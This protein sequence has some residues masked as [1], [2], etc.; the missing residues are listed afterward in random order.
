MSSRKRTLTTAIAAS[1]TAT[2]A[3]AAPAAALTDPLPPHLVDRHAGSDR[4]ETSVAV[5]QAGHPDGATVAY[6]NCRA[7]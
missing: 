2:A 4:F 1:L 5:S 6:I 7:A 3:F